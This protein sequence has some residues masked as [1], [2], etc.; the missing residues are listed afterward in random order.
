M[1]TAPNEDEAKTVQNETKMVQNG[2]KMAETE[3]KPPKP[4]QNSSTR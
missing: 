3:N 4:W 2:A 1:W